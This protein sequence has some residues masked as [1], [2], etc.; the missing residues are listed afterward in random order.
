MFDWTLVGGA[1]VLLLS[2]VLHYWWTRPEAQNVSDVT[3]L[4]ILAS[5]GLAPLALALAALY[6]VYFWGVRGATPGQELMG[7]EVVDESGTRLIGIPQAFMRL[8]G[9]GLSFALLG[10]GFLIVAFGDRALHDRIAGTR[11]VR[12]RGARA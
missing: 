12:K 2:P 9:Y 11:V 8:L 3:F 7:I 5:I 4:P 1:Q 6:F 10:A